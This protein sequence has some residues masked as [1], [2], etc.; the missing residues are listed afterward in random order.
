MRNLDAWYDVQDE[1]E[2]GGD[3]AA[4]VLS[5][6]YHL[7]V[8]NSEALRL[9]RENGGIEGLVPVRPFLKVESS[10]AM[11]NGEVN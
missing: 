10:E 8:S 6:A 4:D 9:L 7:K 11:E 3:E 5:I 1:L 2:I